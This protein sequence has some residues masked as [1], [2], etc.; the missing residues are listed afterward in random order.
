MATSIPTFRSSQYTQ[1]SQTNILS[2]DHACYHKKI[3]DAST[4]QRANAIEKS[5]GSGVMA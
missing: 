5:I 3:T 2:I 4:L 1:F